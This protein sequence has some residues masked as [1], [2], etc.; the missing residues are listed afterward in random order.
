VEHGAKPATFS[1][2]TQKTKAGI[3]TWCALLVTIGSLG[4]HSAPA[5]SDLSAPVT[6]LADALAVNGC[7]YNRPIGQ[8]VVALYCNGSIYGT[9]NF[10]PENGSY[11]I[12]ITARGDLVPGLSPNAQLSIG[13]SLIANLSVTTP[14]F[15][16]FTQNNVSVTSG[17]HSLGITFTNDYYIPTANQDLNLYVQSITI[18]PNV[19][20]TTGP[21][22]PGTIVLTVGPRGQYQTISDAVSTADADPNPSNY[23]HVQVMPGT[24]TNDFPVMTRPMTIE[25]NPD[26]VSQNV[27]LNATPDLDSRTGFRHREWQKCWRLIKP[28][29]KCGAKI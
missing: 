20:P 27:V 1:V 24:Y 18:A 23:Y 25:V 22:N 13:G 5:K 17:N 9:V 28:G 15:S 6:L 19:P 21:S 16:T 14:D 4:L 8:G 29:Q 10:P 2:F 26:Y 11:Q 3:R 7:V 12:S